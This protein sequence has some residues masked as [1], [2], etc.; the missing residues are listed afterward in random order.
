MQAISTA[1]QGNGTLHP[2]IL[3][4][5]LLGN[6]GLDSLGSNHFAALCFQSHSG[7]ILAERVDH[8]PLRQQAL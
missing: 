7:F 5:P 6:L 1:Q 3:S 2:E 4:P 8:F